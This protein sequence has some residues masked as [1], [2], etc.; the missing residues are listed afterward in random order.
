MK[1]INFIV[2]LI[3]L[4]SGLSSQLQAQEANNELILSV[5][6][7]A[8]FRTYEERPE[9]YE[10]EKVLEIGKKHSIFYGFS[11]TRRDEVKDSILS[12]GGTLS[13]VLN[14]YEK[15]GYKLS[16]QS[17]KV[18]KNF[19]SRGKLTYTDTNFKTFKYV[20]DMERPSWKMLEGDTV[21]CEFPCQKAETIFRGRTWTV[22]FTPEIPI[23]EGPWKLY[24]LPGL[25]LQASDATGSFSFQCTAIH[26]GKGEKMKQLKGRFVRCTPSELRE[27]HVLIGKDPMAYARNFGVPK[28]TAYGPDGKTIVYKEKLKRS[29]C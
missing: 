23:S 21:V 12:R 6:Y 27:M 8:T 16:K 4:G 17:Y 22:W 11:N 29:S 10:D 28:H 7:D 5:R 18:L 2:G 1:H 20:E 25:I 9:L 13:D 19:P 24:G 14:T 3:L 15:F 26:Q